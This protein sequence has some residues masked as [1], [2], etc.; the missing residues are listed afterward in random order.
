MI[1]YAI[2]MF[3][4]ATLAIYLILH[5]KLNNKTNKN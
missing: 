4:V 2:Q 5:V 3:M 1:L